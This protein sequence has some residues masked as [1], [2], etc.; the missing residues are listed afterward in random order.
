MDSDEAERWAEEEDKR[1]R[2]KLLEKG[3][4]PAKPAKKKSG[5]R[6]RSP[7][8]SDD[9]RPRK[10]SSHSSAGAGNR[11]LGSKSSV[12]SAGASGGN[13]GGRSLGS[14][15]GKRCV[16]RSCCCLLCFTSVSAMLQVCLLERRWCNFLPAL[17]S[18]LKHGRGGADQ[19]SGSICCLS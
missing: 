19:L 1:G 17:F 13:K 16:S 11:P 9:D 14:S 4:V 10:K 12:S 2:E 15:K 18:L 8:D 6:D 3:G 7:D 5:H